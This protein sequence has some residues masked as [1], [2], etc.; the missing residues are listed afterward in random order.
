M[1][2]SYPLSVKALRR[3]DPV[4]DLFLLLLS[5]PVVNYLSE[6]LFHD[7]FSTWRGLVLGS[8]SGVFEVLRVVAEEVA[9]NDV[10]KR[11]LRLRS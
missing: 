8:F 7:I 11:V 1:H 6:Q 3:Y 4:L 2:Q 10:I 5:L 9:S